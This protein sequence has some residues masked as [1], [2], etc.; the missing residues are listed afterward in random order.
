MKLSFPDG[1]DVEVINLNTLKK[2]QEISKSISNKEHVTFFV[3]RSKL[4][5]KLN[6][7]CYRN[8]SNRRWT[9]D[10]LKDYFF[11]KKVLS[12]FSHNIYFSWKNLIKA[13]KIKKYLINKKER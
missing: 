5:K 1:L 3:K 8:Y 12:Y 7:K 13:E 6:Y 2:S 9:L 11:L 4:F 10:Y